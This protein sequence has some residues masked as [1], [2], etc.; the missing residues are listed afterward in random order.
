MGL[1]RRQVENLVLRGP[2]FYWRARIPRGLGASG[3][4]AR[5]SLSLRLSDRKKASLVARRLN[6]LLLQVE[7][8]PTARMA[9][10]EQLTRIF[11]LE[12]EAMHEEIEALDRSAKHL[13]S[14]RDPVHRDA[15]RQVGWAYRLLHAYGITEE[16]SFEEGGEVRE[17][18]I[19]AGA[20]PE[21]IPFIA[22]TYESERQGALSDRE[23][24]TRSPFLRDVVHRMA[25]VG[26][27]DTVLN[28]EAATEEI[29]RARAEAL[30]A[31]AAKPRRPKLTGGT[32]QPERIAV[33]AAPVPPPARPA[34]SWTADPEAAEAPLTHPVPSRETPPPRLAAATIEVPSVATGPVPAAPA[35]GKARKD[36][37]LSGFDEEL[38]KLI[39]N[40]QDEWEEDTASDVRVLVGVFRGI[41]AEHDVTHSG[42]I[43]QEHVAALRQHFNH[44]LP[45]WGR[46]PR[47]R[48]LTP[49]ELRD[50][51]RRRAEE[52]RRRGK[53]SDL[54]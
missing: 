19:E 52:P 7:L 10:K 49:R 21:D 4:N 25:Q 42:E 16:L 47:L 29:F 5:L 32:D 13:G 41:L 53:P 20:A 48:S 14:L 18:L 54:G 1:R 15:D 22:A 9:T 8:M 35:K 46:S 39:A 26:L 12:I 51:S 17:A 44:I 2:I 6:A 38:E 43:T 11:A 40:H 3:R 28:R 23:G 50:E 30:L 27:D 33:E 34:V 36:L 45:H 37:P 24:R 31:S